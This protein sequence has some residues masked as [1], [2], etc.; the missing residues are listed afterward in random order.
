MTSHILPNLALLNLFMKKEY[1]ERWW[2]LINKEVI[3]D[4][5]R[6]LFNDFYIYYKDTD[7][8]EIEPNE[9]FLWFSQ[10]RHTKL[11]KVE[12]DLYS[13]MLHKATAYEIENPDNII[14]HFHLKELQE[15]LKAELNKDTFNEE[16]IETLMEEYSDKIVKTDYEKLFC[17]LG[18]QELFSEEF[19]SPV[20]HYKLKCIENATGGIRSTDFIIV[21]A[22]IH[23]G[24]SAFLV[25][26][27]VHAARQTEDRKIYYLVNE[28]SK[29]Q[30]KQK[31]IKAAIIQNKREEL[32]VPSSR[33]LINDFNKC[34]NTKKD[35][36]YSNIVGDRDK[37]E[38][39][40]ISGMNIYS[41]CNMMKKVKKVGMI[42]IDL[43]S[44]VG[45]K[46]DSEHS[47]MVLR[48]E[49][50][51]DLAKKLNVPIIGAFQGAPGTS[52]TDQKSGDTVVKKYIH[53]SDIAGAK[54][55]AGPTDVFIGI[56]HDNMY[57][58]TRTIYISKNRSGGT[59][60]KEDVEF[61]GEEYSYRD[62]V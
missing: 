28:E 23:T 13:E 53:M 27:A 57:P 56:G 9:F 61:I 18:A 14:K 44:K 2:S 37:I 52:W 22:P 62:L 55:A 4:E 36:L 35:L 38:V 26:M 54:N 12:Y 60:L 46:A 10:T 20:F 3:S 45:V 42:I 30:V 40:D 50:I 29:E 1:F 19:I 24:K 51:K 17:R 33:S 11:E 39:V 6:L 49:L 21:A 31:L 59:L 34:C 47:M 5:L 43:V 25:D 58:S 32:L 8:I 48:S 15:K 41:I 7:S 16:A